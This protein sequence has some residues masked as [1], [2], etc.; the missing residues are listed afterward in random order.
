MEETAS[1]YVADCVPE[2]FRIFHPYMTRTVLSGLAKDLEE[3]LFEPE[4]QVS[5]AD[6]WIAKILL[7][8][9]DV[10]IELLSKE[11][12][13][14]LELYVHRPKEVE[15]AA[16]NAYRLID[17]GRLEEAQQEAAKIPT[18]DCETT[19]LEVTISIK[20]RMKRF[21]EAKDNL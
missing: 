2:Y 15:E 10:P 12:T 9:A 17:E 13:S 20:R 19:K 11:L 18:Y 21:K 7:E 5:E 4:Y 14:R 16:Q 8:C 1:A 6:I 3:R